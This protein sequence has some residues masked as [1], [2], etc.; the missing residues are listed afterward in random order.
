MMIIPCT[1]ASKRI[2]YVGINQPEELKDLYLENYETLMKEIE[3]LQAG[4]DIQY[5][6][7]ERITIV[8]MTI[9]PKAIYTCNPCQNTNG[10]FH[11][12]KTNKLIICMEAQKTLK[13]QNYPEK[14][15][16]S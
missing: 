13:S 12:T 1:V 4:E 6:W 15:D 10:I 11:R 2:K 8:K 9:L 3:I 7:I 14:E 16:Q 5:S